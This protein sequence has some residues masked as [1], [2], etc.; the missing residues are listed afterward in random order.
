[1]LK[2]T[3][4]QTKPAHNKTP[5]V[6][7]LRR[8]LD[9]R[10][11]ALVIIDSE[12]FWTMLRANYEPRP[13]VLTMSGNEFAAIIEK[14][15]GKKIEEILEQPDAD[16]TLQN[17]AREYYRANSPNRIRAEGATV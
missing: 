12:G 4:P 9:P 15:I 6:A 10:Q 3:S 1:M 13:T 7:M 16:Q 5:A 17:A 14:G 8:A 11:G 2:T